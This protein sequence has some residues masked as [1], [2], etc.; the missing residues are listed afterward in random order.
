M[1]DRK[2]KGRE[3]EGKGMKEGRERKKER[4]GEEKNEKEEGCVKK[5]K[6][7]KKEERKKN[8]L[9]RNKLSRPEQCSGKRKNK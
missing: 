1:K 7:N 9:Q 8:Y 5:K 6:K 3:G 4:S 2:R